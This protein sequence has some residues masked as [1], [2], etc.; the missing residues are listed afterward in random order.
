MGL[1]EEGGRGQQRGEDNNTITTRGPHLVLTPCAGVVGW[2]AVFA[3]GSLSGSQVARSCHMCDMSRGRLEVGGDV[4]VDFRSH[5][6][7]AEMRFTDGTE[8]VYQL[9]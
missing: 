1:M 8:H 4:C 3:Y 6:R 7:C 2:P 9:S 5:A